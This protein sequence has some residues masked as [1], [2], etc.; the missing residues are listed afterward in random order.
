MI[1]SHCLCVLIPYLCMFMKNI[2]NFFF[3]KCGLSLLFLDLRRGYRLGARCSSVV[4][5]FA[6][7]A[8]GCQIDPSWWTH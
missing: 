8:M 3:Y 4:R 6:Y 7:G 5:A 1:S 2:C